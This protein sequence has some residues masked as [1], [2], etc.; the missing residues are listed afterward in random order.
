M[1]TPLSVMRGVDGGRCNRPSGRVE[2]EWRAVEVGSGGVVRSTAGW[3]LCSHPPAR[4]SAQEVADPGPAATAISSQTLSIVVPAPRDPEAVS[5]GISRTVPTYPTEPDKRRVRKALSRRAPLLPSDCSG[6]GDPHTEPGPTV[7]PPSCSKDESMAPST[8]AAAAPST[9]H[10]PTT[11]MWSSTSWQCCCGRH[12]R[13][14]AR[15]AARADGARRAPARRLRGSAVPGPRHRDRRPGAGRPHRT[16]QG[17]APLPT[18][19]GARVRGLR[20]A[21]DLRRG[22]ALVPRPGLGRA[23]TTAHPGAARRT[24]RRG[25]AAA[26][27]PSP[28]PARPGDGP[29]SP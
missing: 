5:P 1:R 6:R 14:R 15:R 4:V 9:Q 21:D 18:R 17:G 27:R 3:A 12:R 25:G 19:R 22:Q 26:A 8:P 20:G 29:C 11:S 2:V 24:G 10:G 16:G 23:P 13:R 7:A 28:G